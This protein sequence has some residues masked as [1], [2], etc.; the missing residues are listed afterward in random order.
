MAPHKVP[1]KANMRLAILSDEITKPIPIV[2]PSQM[3]LPF[4]G[5]H[6]GRAFEIFDGVTYRKESNDNYWWD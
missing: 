2:Q 1:F 4:F 5:R 3:S 6:M